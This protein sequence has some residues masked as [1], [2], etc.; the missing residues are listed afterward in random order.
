MSAADFDRLEALFAAALDQPTDQRKA[1]ITRVSGDP[2]ETGELLALLTAHELRGQLDSITDRLRRPRG[3]STLSLH[4]VMTRLGDDL[5]RR[6]RIERELGRGG[7]AIVLL[8]EDLKH[9]RKVAL[10]I[11]HP[12]LALSL[13]SAR[14]LREIA[15]AA[16]LT[17][18]HIL[19][20]HDSGEAGGL[21]YYVM[22]YVEGES[23]RDR[24]RREER[25]GVDES[26]RI[27]R[28][29]ADAL[30][31]AHSRGVV[32]RDIKPENILLESG[33]P[34]VSDFGIARAMTAAGGDELSET[35]I[36]LGTPAYMSPEQVLGAREI[37]GRTDIY[38]LGC[39]LFE[40]LTGT[41][42]FTATSVEAL[43]RQHL[44]APVPVLREI[45][46]EV[47]EIVAAVVARAVSKS[48]GDR[49][50]DA[51]GFSDALPLPGALTGNRS[52]RMLWAAAAGAFV[53]SAAAL[54]TG[55]WNVGPA[56]RPPAC[57]TAWRNERRVRR[58]RAG[59]ISGAHRPRLVSRS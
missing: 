34:V 55:I 33:H 10:K 9:E 25:L 4:D 53:A 51:K 20:L 49:F 36:I 59:R 8:A 35:G 29:V 46:P 52:R 37:D 41:P 40:M 32:H 57:C 14:F 44:S 23:L 13:G 3:P 12:D 28:Q 50:A 16:K 38:G 24:L 22:P 15:I 47:P 54:M 43:L 7:T 2:A 18:P 42:P 31:Y 26:L 6:Y 58:H 19:P 45:R 30:S 27:A 21:L 5:A 56:T 1:Y 39:V 11:L 17:H 48:P